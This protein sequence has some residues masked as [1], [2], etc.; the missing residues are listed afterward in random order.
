MTTTFRS[1]VAGGLHSI[2][3]AFAVANPTLLR[4]AFRARPSS[5]TTDTPFGWVETR[6]ETVRHDSGLRM[7]TMTPSV[8]VV[9]RLTDNIETMDRMD[10]LVDALLDYFTANP[11]ITANTAW[12]QLTIT[13]ETEQLPDGTW[14]SAV[15]FTFGDVIIREGRP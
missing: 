7:R 15:R 9:D 5:W 3:S 13:D 14:I 6:N 8:V 11:H 12:D 1:D 2:L 4:R 10:D